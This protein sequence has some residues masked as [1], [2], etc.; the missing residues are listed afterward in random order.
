VYLAE[1]PEGRIVGHYSLIPTPFRRGGKQ[2][3]AALSIQSMIHP[4][5][6][7]QGILK[8][9]PPQQ[10]SSFRRTGWKWESHF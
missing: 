2:V 1:T 4:D 9:W 7:R 3:L 6:Q 5:F 10:K 8:A